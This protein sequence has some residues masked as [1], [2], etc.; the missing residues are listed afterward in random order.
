MTI[1]RF[2]HHGILAIAITSSALSGCGKSVEQEELDDLKNQISILQ[3]QVDQQE[4]QSEDAF[5]DQGEDSA[6]P[7][8]APNAP[9]SIFP[10]VPTKAPNPSELFEK[11]Q[12]ER[13]LNSLK[14]QTELD[15]MDHDREMSEMREEQ[16]R[17]DR[18]R[19]LGIGF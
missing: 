18:N 6:T 12:I 11:Q 5:E 2:K 13:D 9:V 14:R 10:S 16:E 7:I 4:G 1:F 17:R 8:Q 3:A 19:Q 15:R